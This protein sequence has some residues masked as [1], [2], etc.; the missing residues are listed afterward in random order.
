M[1]YEEKFLKE[2]EEWVNTQVLVNEMAMKESQ[3][4][5]E[6]HGDERAK[7]AVIRY[8][9]RLD[10]YTFLQSKFSNYREKKDF[11]ALPDGMFGTKEY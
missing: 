10:A 3:S 6:E 11:H 1:T 7:D 9:S 2:F 4:V 8:E 5:W